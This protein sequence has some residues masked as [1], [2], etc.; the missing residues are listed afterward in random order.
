MVDE[1][2]YP[3]ALTVAPRPLGNRALPG[4]RCG[5]GSGPAAHFDAA[6]AWILGPF[7]DKLNL[8]FRLSQIHKKNENMTGVALCKFMDGIR[9]EKTILDNCCM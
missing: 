9:L 1:S 4:L 7:L 8:R 3:I 2:L 6:S 5:S